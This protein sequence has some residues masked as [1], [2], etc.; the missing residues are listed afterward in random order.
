VKVFDEMHRGRECIR[1]GQ[2]ADLFG[3]KIHVRSMMSRNRRS[4]WTKLF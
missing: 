1:F 4:R 2:G 3:V